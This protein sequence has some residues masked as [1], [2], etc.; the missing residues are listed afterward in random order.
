MKWYSLV[1][2][3]MLAGC[4]TYV[5]LL[6][7]SGEQPLLIED[8]HRSIHC[9]VRA[10]V[11]EANRQATAIARS[12]NKEIDFYRKW[13]VKYTLTLSVAEDLSLNPN[14]NIVS[15]TAPA[16]LLNPGNTVFTLGTG[17]RI[18][19][20]ATKTNTDNA[21]DTVERIAAKGPCKQGVPKNRLIVFGNDLGL[22]SWML[23]RLNLVREGY[24]TSLTAKESFQYEAKFEI[25][26]RG[27]A[28]PKWTFI[29]R[30]LKDTSGL[31]NAGRNSSHSIVVTFG[32]VEEG[33]QQLAPEAAVAHQSLVNAL[34]TANALGNL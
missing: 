6:T 32:P 25:G 2:I 9:E 4:G 31:F 18:T 30:S 15:P 7:L 8:V 34:Q 3:A 28:D 21:F 12:E 24:I 20:K 26:R 11:A 17:I 33:R 13:G 23:T 19:T 16:N 1:P 29:Q 10:T 5:P 27:N 22:T 14:V